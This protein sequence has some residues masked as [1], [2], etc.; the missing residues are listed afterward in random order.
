MV[1]QKIKNF[2][3]NLQ[4]FCLNKALKIKIFRFSECKYQIIYILRIRKGYKFWLSWLFA[5]D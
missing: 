1:N 4:N 5:K 3:V 2:F